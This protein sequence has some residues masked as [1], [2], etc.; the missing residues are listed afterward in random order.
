MRRHK[1]FWNYL[2]P[3]VVDFPQFVVYLELF[4][5]R[6]CFLIKCTN[7]FEKPFLHKR[8]WE[9]T[10]DSEMTLNG[11]LGHFTPFVVRF[12]PFLDRL[13]ILLKCTN[14]FEK[15]Q[16]TQKLPWIV[17]GWL[18]T[19]CGPFWAISGPFVH[20]N[21]LHK[22]FWEGTNDSE[23]TLNRLW[24]ILHHLWSVLSH[25]WSVCAF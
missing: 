3:F 14:G 17:C 7:G 1:W 22:R 4:L 25:F 16:M 18:S 15:A 10:N 13:C 23:I 21:K 24:Y 9:G 5:I 2:E 8:F 20:F 12:E 19:V 11:L 6:L